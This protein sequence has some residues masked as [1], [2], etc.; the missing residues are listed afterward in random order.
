MSDFAADIFSQ[1]T[2]RFQASKS[3]SGAYAAFFKAPDLQPPTPKPPTSNSQIPAHKRYIEPKRQCF[4]FHTSNLAKSAIRNGNHWTTSDLWRVC[5]TPQN[6]KTATS[7]AKA[8][9]EISEI[10]WNNSEVSDLLPKPAD[11][12]SQV[13]AL[14]LTNCERTIPDLNA[15]LV[16]RLDINE[17]LRNFYENSRP[18]HVS[19]STTCN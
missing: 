18:L 9:S 8:N 13:Q 17:K 14:I 16:R 6:S 15:S 11:D 12:N 2:C 5:C 1:L 7:Y 19:D 3:A 4:K 10:V